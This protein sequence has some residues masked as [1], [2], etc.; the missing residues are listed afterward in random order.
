[1]KNSKIVIVGL[2]VIVALGAVYITLNKPNNIK[3]STPISEVQNPLKTLT[4]DEIGLTFS[5]PRDFSYRK[6]IGDNLGQ[7]HT[8]AFYV[9][10]GDP[11]KPD[12]QL[13]GLFLADKQSSITDLEKSKTEM[14][15]S[16]IKEASIGGYTGIEGL[17]LGPKTR[18]I[19]S[20]LKD[21]HLFSVSTFPPTPENKALTDSIISSLSFK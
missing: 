15:K 6:E 1:M 4:V 9:E 11:Q 16:T 8:V 7:L 17:I 21:G 5:Y 3:S 20:V 18:Y 14:D 2:V 10:K 19:T 12:Y 13:Y